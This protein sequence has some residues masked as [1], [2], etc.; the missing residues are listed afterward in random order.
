MNFGKTELVV[1]S[2]CETGL[3]KDI[4]GEGLIG[5]TL[6]IGQLLLC[7]ASGSRIGCLYCK[8]HNYF[9]K[10]SCFR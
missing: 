8:I 4:K 7:K 1:L 3:G 6:I 10:I 5:L 9:K 2:A